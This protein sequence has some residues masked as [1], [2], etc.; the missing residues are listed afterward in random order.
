MDI[1]QQ[2]TKIVSEHLGLGVDPQSLSKTHNSIW[3]NSRKKS[4][5]GFRLT[6]EGYSIFVEKMDMKK[7]EIEFPKEMTVTNQ[8]MIWLDRFIDGPYYFNKKSI[9]VFK[10][11]TAVQLIL[12]S[13]DV[14]KFGIAKAMSNS[15]EE[16]QKL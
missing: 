11:K 6:D 16:S 12:F 1:K 15:K 13:G 4:Q 14:Q 3:Q 2:L 5:G 8:V 7:Y 10:E 9:I